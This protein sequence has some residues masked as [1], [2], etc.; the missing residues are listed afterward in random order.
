MSSYDLTDKKTKAVLVALQL[1]GISDEEHK[2]SM[3]ELGRLVETLGFEVVAKLS[4]KRQSQS[5]AAIL[6]RG[7]LKEL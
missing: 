3:A 5:T 4:Q 1:P 2:G 6:G 7:K